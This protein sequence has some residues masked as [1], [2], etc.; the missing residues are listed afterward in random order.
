MFRINMNLL[1]YFAA[2]GWLLEQCEQNRVG[3]LLVLM[4]WTQQ[5]LENHPQ[6]QH[7]SDA[8][9][10]TLL[11]LLETSLSIYKFSHSSHSERPWPSSKHIVETARCLK[12]K[13]YRWFAYTSNSPCFWDTVCLPSLI[14]SSS[15]TSSGQWDA[16]EIHYVSPRLSI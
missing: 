9:S 2:I 7:I 4:D 6:F 16:K 8:V 11:A 5:I 15:P 3:S 14:Y 1:V 10:E 13:D 12:I